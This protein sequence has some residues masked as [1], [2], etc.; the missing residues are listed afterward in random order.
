VDQLILLFSVSGFCAGEGG[1]SL[2]VRTKKGYSLG[3]KVDYVFRVTQHSRDI[4]LMELFISF[5]GT[6]K[7]IPDQTL[8][9]LDVIF[10]FRM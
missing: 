2:L 1:F 10:W 8:L 3:E 9:T 4:A 6:G 7:R 5:L